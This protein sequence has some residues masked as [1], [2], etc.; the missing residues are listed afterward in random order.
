[1]KKCGNFFP[2]TLANL[3]PKKL[4]RKMK[5]SHTFQKTFV[6][7]TRKSVEKQ[8]TYRV[9]RDFILFYFHMVDNYNAI[10]TFLKNNLP[11]SKG[12][13]IHQEHSCMSIT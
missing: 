8:F 10:F 9:L 6:E 1:M 7:N 13:Q 2:K 11:T 3:V 5:L 4:C 12:Q